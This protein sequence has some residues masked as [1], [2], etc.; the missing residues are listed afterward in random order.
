[1]RWPL[2]TGWI[3]LAVLRLAGRM[4]TRLRQ[5]DPTPAAAP[6]ATAA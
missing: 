2:A 1:M 5:Q 3:V 6:N 4:L